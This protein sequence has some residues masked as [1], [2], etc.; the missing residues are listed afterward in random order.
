MA[1]GFGDKINFT[2]SGTMYPCLTEDEVK[3]AIESASEANEMGKGK[4]PAV[5]LDRAAALKFEPEM[6]P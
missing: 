3:W 6:G 1:E 4:P 2:K 5:Y